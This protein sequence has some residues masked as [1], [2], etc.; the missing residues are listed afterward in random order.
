L[1][2]RVDV[3]QAVRDGEWK[4]CLNIPG[5]IHKDLDTWK[6]LVV[7]GYATHALGFN[8]PD[9]GDQAYLDPT[10]AATLWHQYMTPLRS[11]GYSLV[12]PA[13]TSGASGMTWMKTFL[14]ACGANCV[15]KIALH[16]YGTDAQALIEYIKLWY[17]T[18]NKVIWVT[19]FACMDFVNYQPCPNVEAFAGTVKNF[20][21]N[22]WYV[23]AYFPFAITYSLG[24]V[25]TVNQ[26][27]GGDLKPTTLGWNYF[28]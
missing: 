20:M 13:T 4:V 8:E 7:P 11:S 19:E 10:Y 26:L 17:N 21:D 15:D 22:T 18:F 16:W 25:N 23:E 1:I 12:S 24:N 9:L 3:A 14:G 6:Q 5:V 27:L 28:S 2:Y